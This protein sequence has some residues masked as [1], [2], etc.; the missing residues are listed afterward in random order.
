MDWDNVKAWNMCAIEVGMAENAAVWMLIPTTT[1][2]LVST[3]P[4]T[5]GSSV[6]QMCQRPD[7]DMLSWPTLTEKGQEVFSPSLVQGH[8]S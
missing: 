8:L 6:E 3:S 5:S 2:P 1:L 4:V 7:R